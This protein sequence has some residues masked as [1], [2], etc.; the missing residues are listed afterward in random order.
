MALDAIADGRRMNC[1]LEGG[2][3]HVGMTRDAQRLGGC[4]GELNAGDVFVNPDFVTAR[5]THRNGGVNEFALGFVLVTLDTGC[6][7]GVW[8]ERYRMDASK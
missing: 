4:R 7:I 5:T 1:P 3:V 2:R 6:R 8:F